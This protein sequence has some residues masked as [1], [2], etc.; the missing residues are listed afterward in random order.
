MKAMGY[1]A[2]NLLFFSPSEE[3]AARHGL[4]S[5]GHQSKFE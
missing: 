4:L 1:A 2:K 3:L 5:G